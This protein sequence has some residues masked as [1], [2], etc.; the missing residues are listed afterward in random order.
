MECWAAESYGIL[1]IH[2]IGKAFSLK[3][4]TNKNGFLE[5]V[6]VCE[7]KERKEEITAL[8]YVSDLQ[9]KSLQ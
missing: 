2:N 6:Y 9:S 5:D 1:L 3:Y 4:S 7:V 8:Q